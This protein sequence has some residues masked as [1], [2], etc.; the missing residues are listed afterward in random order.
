MKQ[1]EHGNFSG[2]PIALIK[3]LI[4]IIEQRTK[5]EDCLKLVAKNNAKLPIL[6]PKKRIRV[7]AHKAAAITCRECKQCYDG[8]AYYHICYQVH[9]KWVKSTYLK[10]NLISDTGTYYEFAVRN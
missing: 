1:V 3:A 10:S 4:V 9:S 5:L 8:S 2:M 6:K 7:R